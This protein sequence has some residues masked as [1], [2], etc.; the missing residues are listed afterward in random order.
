[1]PN[2]RIETNVSKDSI[3]MKACLSELSKALAA[4]TGKP[5]QYML[6]QVIHCIYKLNI[7]ILNLFV[8]YS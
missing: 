1:M 2:L 3:D 7:L 4:T 6:I 5:E 8:G